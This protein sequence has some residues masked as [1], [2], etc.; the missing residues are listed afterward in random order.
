MENVQLFHG[1]CLEVMKNIPDKSVDLVLIYGI[2]QSIQI[3]VKSHF[4]VFAVFFIFYAMLIG[5][6]I[7]T[8]IL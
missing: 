1:D 2:I 5:L 6:F 4:F 8:H 3:K 7:Y